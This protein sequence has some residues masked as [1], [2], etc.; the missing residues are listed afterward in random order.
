M[1]STKATSSGSHQS[2]ILPRMKPSIASA[3]SVAPGLHTTTSSG[4]SCQ[5]GCGTAITA[6]CNTAGWPMA[7]F[8]S[9]TELIHSPPDLITSLLRS[10]SWMR[11][12]GAM[13]A[14]SPVFSQPC[15]STALPPSFLK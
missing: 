1:L 15:S 14:R 7:R 4:R 2:T 6:A 11:P 10:V 13:V 3:S 12:S 9:S 8:S 5:R